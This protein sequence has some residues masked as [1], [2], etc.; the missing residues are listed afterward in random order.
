M[1]KAQINLEN[2]KTKKSKVFTGR[3]R[4]KE[5]RKKSNIDSLEAENE[6]IEIIVPEEIYS[7]NP[8]FLEE[9]LLNV[10]VKLKKNTFLQ[11]FTFTSKGEYNIEQDLNEAIDRILR[12]KNA[13]SI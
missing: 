12:D 9:F 8:S 1:K 4:G 5:V 10:V 6:V 13:L 7:I 3:E 11:R 2:F